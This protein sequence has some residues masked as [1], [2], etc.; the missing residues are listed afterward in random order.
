MTSRSPSAAKEHSLVTWLFLHPQT[1]SLSHGTSR[2]EPADLT[3]LSVLPTSPQVL[4]STGPTGIVY[5][6]MHRVWLLLSE[7]EPSNNDRQVG[8]V[9]AGA[10]AAPRDPQPGMDFQ[11]ADPGRVGRHWERE[12]TSTLGRG[13]QEQRLAPEKHST[14]A[15]A[16][17]PVTPG[18][19]IEEGRPG[20]GAAKVMRPLG[21]G[22]PENSRSQQR[23]RSKAAQEDGQLRKWREQARLLQGKGVTCAKCMWGSRATI[24]TLTPAVEP[25]GP[26]PCPTFSILKAWQH[27]K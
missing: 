22:S 1:F 16:S 14:V 26:F 24:V 15:P 23:A 12:G 10:P 27:R 9:P 3:G 6:K 5:P 18:P 2:V 4:G 21:L 8:A 25:A 19:S 17:L 20:D 11:S 7:A 13:Q